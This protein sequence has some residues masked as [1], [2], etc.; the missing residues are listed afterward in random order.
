[1]T[2]RG[3]IAI[4]PRSL[5]E[6]VR[7]WWGARVEG[8][9][10]RLLV[11]LGLSPNALTLLGLLLTAPSAYLCAT[12][13]WT[14]AGLVYLLA[15]AMDLLDGALARRTGR[16]SRFGAFLDSLVDRAQEAGV[17]LGVV[18][19]Y[20]QRG[21]TMGVLMTVLALTG[22]FL[23]SYAHARA[24]GL[25]VPSPQGGMMTRP[26]RVLI[27][28]AGFLTGWLLPALGV[29]AGLGILTA[30]HRAYEVWRATRGQR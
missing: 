9:L 6:G 4:S 30:L 27:L 3:R 11:A 7:A 25:G 26:E 15:G 12:G 10:V 13:R 23:V 22:S 8:P 20:A 1:M 14:A 5:R 29:V 28:A 19:F 2:L 17:L 24:E 18:A 16:A 21:H